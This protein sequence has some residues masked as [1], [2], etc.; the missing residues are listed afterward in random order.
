MK[1]MIALHVSVDAKNDRECS[2]ACPFFKRTPGAYLVDTRC[3]LFDTQLMLSPPF[4][5]DPLRAKGCLTA[6]ARMKAAQR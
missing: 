3:K 6:D 4:Y 5:Q 1:R 2:V